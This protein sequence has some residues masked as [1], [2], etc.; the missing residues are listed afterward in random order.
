MVPMRSTAPRS[1][2]LSTVALNVA[3]LDLFGFEEFVAEVVDDL[4]VM[5]HCGG[6]FAGGDRIDYGGFEAVFQAVA[7][8]SVPL[9]LRSPEAGGD[10]D[11]EFVELARNRGVVAHL[12]AELLCEIAHFRAA[13]ED[14]E[15]PGYG[16]ALAG[17]YVVDEFLLLGRE[18]FVG[19]RFEAIA[20][21]VEL[22]RLRESQCGAAEDE[23]S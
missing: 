20:A 11:G 8:V 16:G 12:G 15:G 2:N 23:E 13:E 18:L 3:S 22:R 19:E 14:V 5:I 1:P 10:E 21:Q 7:R 9:V 17:E 6:A 4:F